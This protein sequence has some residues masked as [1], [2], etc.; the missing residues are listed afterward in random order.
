MGNKPASG[1]SILDLHV[2]TGGGHHS[3]GSGPSNHTRRPPDGQRRSGTMTHQDYC[4][5]LWGKN[6][7]ALTG[8]SRMIFSP[9]VQSHQLQHTAG[10]FRRRRAKLLYRC[11]DVISHH[12][13]KCDNGELSKAAL[14]TGPFRMLMYSTRMER[15][16]WQL[17]F[18]QI[19]KSWPAFFGMCPP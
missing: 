1:S 4:I 12:D 18:D 2:G 6:R 9:T 5:D 10:F 3:S 11:A 19:I 17:I 7:H 16:S 8:A 14:L 13:T 15:R